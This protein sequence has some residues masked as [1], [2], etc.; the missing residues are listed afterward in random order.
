MIARNRVGY[1]ASFPTD[2]TRRGYEFAG[3]LAEDGVTVLT[4]TNTYSYDGCMTFVAKWNARK[5]TITYDLTDATNAADLASR[6]NVRYNVTFGDYVGEMPVPTKTGYRFTGWY[7]AEDGNG[8]LYSSDTVYS[9][10]DDVTLYAGWTAMVFTI[11]FDAGEGALLD[12]DRDY[13]TYGKSL[14]NL[15]TPTK[16]GYTFAGWYTES[17]ERYTVATKYTLTDNLTLYALWV[18]TNR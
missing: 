7:T 4:A 3:W 5:Y 9:I 10:S 13:F 17:G 18:E 14:E 1:I 12:M 2:V 15:P 8:T 6:F 16:T 11:Y